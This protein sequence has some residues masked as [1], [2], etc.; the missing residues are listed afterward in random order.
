MKAPLRTILAVVLLLMGISAVHAEKRVALIIGNSAYAKVEK[1][2]NPAND[3]KRLAKALGSIGFD[4]V[5][6]KLD[7]SY[8][9]L[10]RTLGQ[11]S[12]EA[13]G[14]DIALIYFAGHGLEVGGVNYVIP[15]DATLAHV[16]DVEFEAVELSK[17]MSSLNR[18]GKL[19]LVILD[20]CRNNPFKVK[21]ASA[22]STRSV[23]RGLARVSPTGSDTL[24][25][26]AAKEGTVADDGE[27]ENSPYATALIKHISTPG[28]D[29]RLMFGRVRDD[30]LAS[31]GRRQEPYTYG[32]LGGSAIHLSALQTAA[33]ALG[34]ASS[35]GASSQPSAEQLAAETRRIKQEAVKA[36][37]NM[38]RISSDPVVINSF[39]AQYPNSP[40]VAEARRRVEKLENEQKLAA[41]PAAPDDALSDAE[42]KDPRTLAL[43]L[44]RELNRVGCDI[45]RPDGA[46][47][48]RSRRGLRTY[49][50][51]AKVKLT[52]L[53]PSAEILKDIMGRRY[54][55]C[56]LSCSAR[57][58]VKDG[59]CVLK[60]CPTGQ[61][62][63]QNGDCRTVAPKRSKE[64]QAV[65]GSAP[66]CQ[67][68]TLS[69][70]RSR[71]RRMSASQRRKLRGPP[72]RKCLP[73]L[74]KRVCN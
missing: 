73:H 36:L 35:P 10:R 39:I 4:K 12:R 40:H 14:A 64:R 51:H 57:Q 32:S 28:L 22:G 34:A 19:K 21:M 66:R 72:G 71:I 27:G 8:G 31:T 1:L 24:V 23:G 52:G 44:Q 59:R 38:V 67:L 70:C 42:L 33:P 15:T 49:A 63:M 60:V 5:T 11:F 45:G 9:A 29:I 2:K 46:W 16:D 30:V 7:Q 54:L 18:A 17:L 61:K 3:A 65:G 68:E 25:A 6:L 48:A 56:P 62:L 41:L 13:A 50:R 74:R 69:Q 55:V 26:Y 53:E 20:A 58:V 37:W 47:G 43:K